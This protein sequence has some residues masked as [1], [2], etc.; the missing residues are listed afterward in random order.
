[1]PQIPFIFEF[2]TEFNYAVEKAL[3]RTSTPQEAFTAA[4]TKVNKIIA[5]RAEDRKS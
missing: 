2:E 3:R 4:T 1:M 5:R